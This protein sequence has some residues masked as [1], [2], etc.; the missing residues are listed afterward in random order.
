LNISQLFD[1]VEL[2]GYWQ[3]IVRRESVKFGADLEHIINLAEVKRISIY[4]D[5]TDIWFF[6]M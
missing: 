6:S 3:E 2:F 4:M 1:F 5:S